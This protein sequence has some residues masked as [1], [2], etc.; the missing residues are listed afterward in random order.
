MKNNSRTIKENAKP[1]HSHIEKTLSQLI[2]ENEQQ[3]KPLIKKKKIKAK[4]FVPCQECAL[5]KDNKCTR[6]GTC[7][8]L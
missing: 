2:Y 8:N 7:I 3:E 4:K 5:F 6:T 1:K